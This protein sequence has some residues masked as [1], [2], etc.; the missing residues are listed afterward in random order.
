MKQ[1]FQN[2]KSG[3]TTVKEVIPPRL[4]NGGVLV[5]NNFSLLSPGTERN[6]VSVSKKNLI[7]KAKER[8]D[9]VE[10]FFMLWKTKGLKAA[11]DVAKSKLETE[12]ALGYS[13]SGKIIEVAKNISEF[14][15]GDRVACAGQDYASHAEYVF[16]P[17]NLCVKIPRGVSDEEASFTTI[18]SIVLHGI[19]RAEL[20]EGEK[21]AVVGL[22]LLGQIAVRILKAYGYQ[23]IGF[24]IQKD[25]VN[26]AKAN[27]ADEALLINGKSI[28]SEIDAFTSGKGVDAVLIYASAKTDDPLKLAVEISREKGRIVQIGNILTNIPWRDFYKKELSYN[29]SR[30]YGPGRYDPNYE[31]GGGDYPFS[32]V[33]WTEKRNMEEFLRLLDKKMIS[34]KDLISGSYSIDEGAR[35]YEEILN[36]KKGGVFG[37]LLKYQDNS[38]YEKSIFLNKAEAVESASTINIGLV[39]LGSFAVSTILP[40]LKE[41]KD[42]GVRLRAICHTSGGR[43]DNVAKKWGADY[44]TNDYEELLKDEKINLIICATRH[45]SHAKI[46]EK[47]LAADK[48]IYIEKPLALNEEDLLRVLKVAEKSKGRLL[49]GFNRR[50]SKHFEAAKKNFENNVPLQIIYRVNSPSLESGH[51]S[52]KQEEGGRLIGE[53]CHFVHALNFLIGGKPVRIST[54]SIPVAG[55]IINEENFSITL[56]YDNGSLGTIIYSALG[57]FKLPKEYIEIYG[58]GK[59][60]T[61]D[62]F[63]KAKVF[64]PNKT[65][66]ISL[67]HQNKGYTEELKILI[68]AI[69]SGAASPMSPQE[70]WDAHL[71]IFKAEEALKTG[72]IIEI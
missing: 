51:W 19:H 41:I 62:N 55:A 66:K 64:T 63:K 44:I 67:W 12:I 38:S 31:E 3:L 49:V 2:P 21:I 10:K 22:G 20:S 25:K 5:K 17:K 61:I 14:Q 69:K 71:A 56:E 33:R 1:V 48:N 37:L 65:E 26:L 28:K 68:D 4:K 43:A 24:D 9:Y 42:A 36:P 40:H 30:S 6:I 23:V 27:G 47:C 16:V 54:N 70:I 32:Y 11:L 45:S 13:T 46:A 52:Y 60:M 53:C 57:N 35:A 29:A 50:F 15:I 58:A 39:G 7:Q 8:P 59:I 34:V 72:K 18:G